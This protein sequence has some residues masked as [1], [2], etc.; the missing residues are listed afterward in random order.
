MKRLLLDVDGVL[1]N[2]TKTAVDLINRMFDRSYATEQVTKFSIEDSL[3]LSA[4]ERERWTTRLTS[5]P[6][7]CA[8]I[9]PYE[10]AIEAVDRLGR[11]LPVYAVTAPWHTSPT[12]V[13]ERTMWLQRHF[14]I[15]PQRV[16]PTHAKYAVR[17]LVLVDDRL[18]HLE[19]WCAEN[20]E[21]EAYESV[22]VLWRTPHNRDET[23]EGPTVDNWHALE[24]IV[25]LVCAGKHHLIGG[26]R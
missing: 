21:V 6:G 5:T 14:G 16:I 23:W 15:P 11:L 26:V 19:S 17:G 8:S 18:K 9:E 12:W 2:F 4:R 22:G 1:A 7:A 3:G 10:G 25:R 13:Y 20:V 24:E